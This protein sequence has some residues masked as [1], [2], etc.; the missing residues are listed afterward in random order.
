MGSPRS[1]P[2]RS[3]ARRQGRVPESAFLP[4]PH[5]RHSRGLDP[6]LGG[7]APGP[8]AAR[9]GAATS[10]RPAVAVAAMALQRAGALPELGPSHLHDLGKLMLAFATFWA[11]QWL[12]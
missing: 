12:S 3:A 1:R 4:G 2:R 10:A 11:Y 7:A 8:P 9:T 5:G 6:V